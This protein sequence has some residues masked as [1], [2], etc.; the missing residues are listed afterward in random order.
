MF[1]K[2]ISD[3]KP[4]MSGIK[5]KQ[6]SHIFGSDNVAKKYNDLF[7]RDA[8]E[9][10]EQCFDR[11]KELRSTKSNFFKSID[12][13]AWKLVDMWMQIHGLSSR[14]CVS[15]GIINATKAQLQIKSSMLIEGGSP[16]Y[17][18]PTKEFNH[19]E[20]I[21]QAGGAIIFFGWGVEPSL[22]RTGG[23]CMNIET[24]AFIGNFLDFKSNLTSVTS[25]AG[26]DVGFLEKSYDPNSWWAK[27]WL[28]VRKF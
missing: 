16:C 1:Q 25:K 11:V 28:I 6:T 9:L 24:N 26:F 4:S 7:E 18:I 27:Y 19:V 14:R 22:T 12:S 2:E 20:N 3:S 17:S 23:V 8:I 13:E 21:L 15:V 10:V 5:A